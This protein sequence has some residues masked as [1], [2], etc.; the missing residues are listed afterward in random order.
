[1]RDACDEGTTGVVAMVATLLTGAAPETGFGGIGMN[2]RFARRNLLCFNA[3]IDGCMAL[4]R[5]D[6]GSGVVLDL[7]TASVPPADRMRTLL[8]K[9]VAGLANEDDEAL[10][11]AL[12][13]ERVAR[14][15]LDHADDPKLVHVCPWEMA[16]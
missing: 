16:G 12:W 4:R 1:M 7:D 14:M 10:F 13:Q 3:P 5:R 15:L 6:T 2:H 8:P 11:A 9:I